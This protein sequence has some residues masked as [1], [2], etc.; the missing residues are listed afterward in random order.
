MKNIQIPWSL[1]IVQY[2]NV[3]S[4]FF[5]TFYNSHFICWRFLERS[6]FHNIDIKLQ[7]LQSLE[8]ANSIVCLL[9]IDFVGMEIS[10]CTAIIYVTCETWT[11][12]YIPFVS[13]TSQ[14]KN[15]NHVYLNP[16]LYIGLW[17][18]CPHK[19]TCTVQGEFKQ[20]SIPVWES[21]APQRQCNIRSAQRR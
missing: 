2:L 18:I 21:V 6:S 10:H 3:T 12:L 20:Y 17:V 8:V 19:V 7:C 16:L 5:L 13:S 1:V 15:F 4:F 9:M 11:S 14:S